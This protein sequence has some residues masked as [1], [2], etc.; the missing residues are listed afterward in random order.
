MNGK[1]VDNKFCTNCG[2]PLS[3]DSFIGDGATGGNDKGLCSYCREIHGRS[4]RNDGNNAWV[5]DE[6]FKIYNSRGSIKKNIAQA[7][8]ALQ[9]L[10]PSKIVNLAQV[11][12]SIPAHPAGVKYDAL[13]L[14]SGG[15]DSS[16]MLVDLAKRDIKVCAWMLQ[17]GYQSPD[18]IK[19]AA[20]L[21]E[22]LDIPLVIE[23]P[24]K[25]KADA[26]FRIGFGINEKDDPHIVKSAM[27]YGSACWPCFSIIAAK[28]SS[29]CSANNIPFCFIGTQEGQNRLDLNG[30]PVLQG[31]GLPNLQ[32][33]VDKFMNDF[34][35]YARH[36]DPEAA[37]LLK[38]PQA[39][40]TVIIP[41]Y[42]FVKR[43]P[44][45]DQVKFLQRL[46]WEMPK[47]TGACS[48]NCM[49]NELG[50]KV[51]RKR[52]GFD[53]Y[54]VIDA[55]ERRIG[56]DTVRPGKEKFQPEIDETSVNIAAK[57]IKLNAEERNEFG[58]DQ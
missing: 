45:A 13:V 10:M 51:M 26:L 2:M 14:Y 22:K 35:D 20:Q 42:E 54:Q 5:L 16:Y 30:K 25:K 56:N 43:P 8:L 52:F 34:S 37:D 32:F 48:S 36:R 41:F 3:Y 53:L 11:V 7:V 50:R 12:N 46:G 40:N 57:M 21:C 19:N 47:N 28:A 15:K 24:E 39:M 31:R 58:I 29:F 1:T 6:I 27:T 18:A 44:V 38:R 17:Q 4:D 9:R 33:L 49:I 55:H 23:K